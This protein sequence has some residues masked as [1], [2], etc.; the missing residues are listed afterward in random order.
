MGVPGLFKYLN[1]RYILINR[2]SSK[3]KIREIDNLYIDMNGLIHPCFHPENYGHVYPK[4][5][6]EAYVELFLF[7]DYLFDYMKPK[8]LVYLAIDGVAPRAKLNQ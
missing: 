8:K 2:H 3:Q 7:L 4:T 6:E 1:S 5:Y